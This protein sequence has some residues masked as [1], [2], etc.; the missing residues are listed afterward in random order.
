MFRG[1][2]KW[3]IDGRMNLGLMRKWEVRLWMDKII[4]V[5]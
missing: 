2:K 1:S 5:S 3:T 4:H